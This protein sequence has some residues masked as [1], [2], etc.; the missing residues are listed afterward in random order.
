MFDSLPRRAPSW[1]VLLVL[2]G[3]VLGCDSEAPADGAGPDAGLGDVGNDPLAPLDS[4]L[5]NLDAGASGDA[6]VVDSGGGATD[7]GSGGDSGA[8][9]DTGV[10]DAGVTPDAGAIDAGLRDGGVADSG[11]ADSGVVDSGVALDAGGAQ[12]AGAPQ[13]GGVTTGT[14]CDPIAQDCGPGLGCYLALLQAASEEWRC[15]NAG[16]AGM[17]SSCATQN[18]CQPGHV[19]LN[20]PG[21]GCLR[22]CSYPGGACPFGL[23]CQPLSPSGNTG[24]CRAEP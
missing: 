5:S 9:S 16:S 6:L 12:D 18:D 11:V 14:L 21:Y 15:Y 1:P 24:Y 7:S 8:A 2:S 17:G 3:L 4:G 23:P 19:C 20:G 13:D 22:V 10:F